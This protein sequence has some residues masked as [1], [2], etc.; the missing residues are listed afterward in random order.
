MAV[1]GGV[2]LPDGSV[3]VAEVSGAALER[4]SEFWPGLV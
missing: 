1:L 2:P 4:L 3:G